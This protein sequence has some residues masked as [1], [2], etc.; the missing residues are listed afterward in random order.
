MILTFFPIFVAHLWM[1]MGPLG[2]WCGGNYLL[3]SY[4]LFTFSQMAIGYLY[5]LESPIWLR[6]T[7]AMRW[8]PT[9][10]SIIG[11]AI[12]LI[13]AI[14]LIIKVLI[15][16]DIW[17]EFEDVIQAYL[18]VI[19]IPNFIYG[20]YNFA[21]HQWWEWYYARGG[22]YVPTMTISDPT[23]P[24][25]DFIDVKKPPEKEKPKPVNPYICAEN[26]WAC[27]ERN[28]RVCTGVLCDEHCVEHPEWKDTELE[29]SFTKDP[30]YR[31]H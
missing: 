16:G 12:W 2:W 13:S 9:I 26:D 3:I 4:T 18:I 28:D 8:V 25:P 6:F 24:E 29:G 30:N 10:F 11:A 17:K 20:V 7:Y 31:C 14:I 15:N 1:M 27:W 5:A 21:M 23:T 22:F 19:G